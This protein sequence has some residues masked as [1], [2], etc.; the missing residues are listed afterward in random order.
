MSQKTQRSLSLKCRCAPSSSSRTKS[1][2]IGSAI[3][4]RVAVLERRAGRRAVVLEQQ[5]VAEPDVVL[6][7]EH[8]VAERPQHALDLRLR[9]RRKPL[10][11]IGRLDDDLVRADAAHPVEHPLALAVERALDAQRRELVGHDAQVPA[12]AVRPLP[13]CR[14]ASTSGGVTC[15]R[16]GQNGQCSRPIAVAFSKRKSIGRFC[17]SVDTTT[18]RPVM[19]SLR[20]S[21]I[22]KVKVQ[23]FKVQ[24]SR[25]RRRRRS[26]LSRRPARRRQRDRHDV[27]PARAV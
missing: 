23:V 26:G 15:S 9:H 4:W 8:A 2:T 7:I 19:G 17:R 10:V 24:G 1:G 3:S 20:S 18:Q 21:G 5:D 11:V 6:Q 14:Y 27:E 22:R 16:P 12:G 25:F 13:F